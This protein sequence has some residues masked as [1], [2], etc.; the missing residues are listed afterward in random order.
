MSQ[1]QV[2]TF[3]SH[4]SSPPCPLSTHTRNL[5]P[6]SGEVRGMRVMALSVGVGKVRKSS[7]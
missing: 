4:T 3:R 5:P 6:V 7:V 1:A 2:P